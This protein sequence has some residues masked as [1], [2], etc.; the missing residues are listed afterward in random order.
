MLFLCMNYEAH[1]FYNKLI[2]Q[3]ISLQNDILRQN[4]N[5]IV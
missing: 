5:D 4:V 1:R 2:V 3:T